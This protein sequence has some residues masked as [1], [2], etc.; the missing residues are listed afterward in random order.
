[1]WGN[2]MDI[3]FS[4]NDWADGFV[5]HEAGASYLGGYGATPDIVDVSQSFQLGN[6][7]DD[8]SISFDFWEM[9]SWDGESF[10]VR[11]NDDLIDLGRFYHNAGDAQ[12][13]GTFGD[14]DVFVADR[15]R[16][17]EP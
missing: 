10:Y 15:P 9:D 2:I 1:M 13:D 4:N 16:Q 6:R 8:V 12:A 11:I 3:L 17:Y 5:S 7:T 14:F